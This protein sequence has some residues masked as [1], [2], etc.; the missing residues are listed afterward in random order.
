VLEPELET[1]ARFVWDFDDSLA[2]A[3]LDAEASRAETEL[4]GRLGVDAYPTTIWMR[5][6]V[7]VHRVEGALPAAALVQL[8]ATYLMNAESTEVM[9]AERP[10]MFAPV[11]LEPF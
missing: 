1:L 9:R 8:T 5:G 3:K 10:E 11:P 6:G 2:V 7:E 4:A